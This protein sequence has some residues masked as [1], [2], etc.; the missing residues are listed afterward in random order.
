[1]QRFRTTISVHHAIRSGETIMLIERLKSRWTLLGGLIVVV[2]ITALACVQI[3]PTMLPRLTGAF[4]D[5]A[6]ADDL[7][8]AQVVPVIV[9]QPPAA[10][11]AGR[12]TA[13]VTRGTLTDQITM[14][15]RVV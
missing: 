13:V 6:P 10:G 3:G 5:Q 14:S 15:G 11:V 4:S 2:S 12:Q 9:V 8:D 7:G 1:P